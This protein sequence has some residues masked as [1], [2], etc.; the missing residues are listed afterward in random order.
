[1]DLKG[2]KE[3][4]ACSVN[5]DSG[6][7]NCLY[8]LVVLLS[9]FF[10]FALLTNYQAIQLVSQRVD[11]LEKISPHTRIGSSGLDRRL[12]DD[13]AASYIV[14]RLRRNSKSTYATDRL[15]DLLKGDGSTSA[16]LSPEQSAGQSSV[17]ETKQLKHLVRTRRE[18]ARGHSVE[19]N[20][21]GGYVADEVGD[22]ESSL[23]RGIWMD[24]YSRI[25]VGPYSIF[26]L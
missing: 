8:T 17:G 22:E 5:S 23:E 7:L 21:Q 25:P 18:N 4:S 1:M 19:E 16:T 26:I 14:E 15:V 2:S 11:G 10:S 3:D 9:M 6:R 20:G 12:S 13:D 24:T